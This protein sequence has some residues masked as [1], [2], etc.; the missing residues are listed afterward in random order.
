MAARLGVAG[1]AASLEA[2]SPASGEKLTATDATAGVAW[3]GSMKGPWVF[4]AVGAASL[5]ASTILG[6]KQMAMTANSAAADVMNVSHVAAR[7]RV[8]ACIEYHIYPL[9]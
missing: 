1:R 6:A 4:A 9:L 7:R 5:C 2:D 8:S 3:T